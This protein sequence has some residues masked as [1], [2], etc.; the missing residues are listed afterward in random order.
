MLVPFRL[1]AALAGL[2]S[3]LVPLRANAQQVTTLAGSGAH[4]SADGTGTAAT[5]YTP[6]GVAVDGSGNVYVADTEQQQDPED[7]ARRAW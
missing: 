4:G 6:F 5:F 7:H 2:G 3:L 1:I